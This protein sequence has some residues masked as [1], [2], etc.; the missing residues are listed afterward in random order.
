MQITDTSLLSAA[1]LETHRLFSTHHRRGE[2]PISR[3]DEFGVTSRHRLN[4]MYRGPGARERHAA[5]LASATFGTGTRLERADT[6]PVE[7]EA[8]SELARVCGRPGVDLVTVQL[9]RAERG[10]RLDA[11]TDPPV[12][13]RIAS[14]TLEGTALMRVDTREFV[15]APGDVW[16]LDTDT[17]MAAPDAVHGHATLELPRTAIIFRY[18]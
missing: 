1:L 13:S 2:G 17:P 3:R 11:H 5:L 9:T 7:C 10:Y 4:L 15:V 8:I 18:A 16:A 14:L 12:W 6:L